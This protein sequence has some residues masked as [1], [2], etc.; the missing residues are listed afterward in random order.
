MIMQEVLRMKN[1]E[2]M[3]ANGVAESLSIMF[4]KDNCSVIAIQD[5]T[6]DSVTGADLV[7]NLNRLRLFSRFQL[8]RETPEYARLITTDSWGKTHYFRAWK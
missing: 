5:A 6:E 2:I 8:D 3:D 1:P 7:A 4:H